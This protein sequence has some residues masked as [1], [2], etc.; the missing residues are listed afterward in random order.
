VKRRTK[1]SAGIWLGDY[2]KDY[3]LPEQYVRGLLDRRALRCT[4]KDADNNARAS[5]DGGELPPKGWWLSKYTK[6]DY[7]RHSVQG[8]RYPP[9]FPPMYFVKVYPAVTPADTPAKAKGK[10]D[11][12]LEILADI[13]P[14]PG[15]QPVQ[16]WTKVLPEF[17]RRW[18]KLRPDDN[19]DPPV[20][21]TTVNR[22]YQ[23]FLAAPSSK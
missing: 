19:T 16:I 14:A 4:W 3:E 20:E 6:I 2:I 5:D 7:E 22:A 17:R 10:F 21:R 12:V 1:A 23:K 15:L 9:F 8:L 13:K 11:L 18:K